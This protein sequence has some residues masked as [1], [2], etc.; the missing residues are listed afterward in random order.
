MP[1]AYQEWESRAGSTKFADEMR[2]D[3]RGLRFA[4]EVRR[5]LSDIVGPNG[6]ALLSEPAKAH[7][8]EIL[9]K[10]QTR[11]ILLKEISHRDAAFLWEC[12]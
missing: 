7:P 2:L 3:I 4:R 11:R 8:G 6:K 10:T 9:S 5:Q 1:C 12:R